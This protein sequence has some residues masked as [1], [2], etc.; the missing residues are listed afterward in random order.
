MKTLIAILLFAISTAALAATLTMQTATQRTD[1]SALPLSEI[2]GHEIACGDATGSYTRKTF[3]SGANLPDTV[4]DTAR[5]ANI[6]N[7]GNNYCVAR[8]VDTGGRVSADSA[9]EFVVAVDSADPKPP[10]VPPGL[11]INVKR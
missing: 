10:V 1:G 2:S 7:L 11:V 4:Y 3:V 6:L 5:F 8:T 9:N